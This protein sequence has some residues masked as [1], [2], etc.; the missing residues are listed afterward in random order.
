MKTES[1]SIM[2]ITILSNFTWLTLA[3]CVW[4]AISNC[5]PH[6]SERK[7]LNVPISHHWNST[8][9]CTATGT[10]TT[11]NTMVIVEGSLPREASSAAYSSAL[12]D[13][14]DDEDAADVHSVGWCVGIGLMLH[15]SRH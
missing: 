9:V 6:V 5:R 1:A 13:D 4:S 15:P 7:T 12:L 11:T 10:A 8:S 3:V 2:Q 14:D